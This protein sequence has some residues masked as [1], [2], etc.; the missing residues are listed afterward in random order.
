MQKLKDYCIHYFYNEDARK[1]IK[2]IMT[3]IGE[4][5][6]NEIYVYLWVICFYNIF[7]FVIILANLYILLKILNFVREMRIYV[8]E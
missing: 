2:E 3:P 1:D 7:L 5:V 6:Y 8:N 4:I